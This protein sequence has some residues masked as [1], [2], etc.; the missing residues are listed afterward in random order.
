MHISV[1]VCLSNFNV[2][3][4]TPAIEIVKESSLEN[5]MDRLRAKSGQY[6]SWPEMSKSLRVAITVWTY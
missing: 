6:K 1:C 5:L 3:L 4:E 2:L